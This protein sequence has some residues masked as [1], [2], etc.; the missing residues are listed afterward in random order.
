MPRTARRPLDPG[1][2]HLTARGNR[3]EPLFLTDRDRV[4]FLQELS[5]AAAPETFLVR[6]YCLMSTHYHLLIDAST[7]ELSDPMRDLNGI[8]AKW[9]N[10]EH[11]FRGN[12]FEGRF[13]STRIEGD[14][15]LFELLRY[16][17]LNPV[18]AGLCDMAPSW[19]WGSFAAVMGQVPRPRFLDTAWTLRLFSSDDA[20]ARRQLSDLVSHTTED[21][22]S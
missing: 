13:H 18:R 11:C 2:Y 6:G 20:D 21:A 8:Y 22:T 12:L 14:W 4:V 15:H 9:F 5:R 10:R 17:A 7:G 16:L 19:R 3:R 1:L